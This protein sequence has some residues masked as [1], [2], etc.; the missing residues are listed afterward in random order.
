LYHQEAW[1]EQEKSI[2]EDQS[3]EAHRQGYE[4]E[5]EDLEVIPAPGSRGYG[6]ARQCPRGRSSCKCREDADI[7]PTNS[8]NSTAP[9][10]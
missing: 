2:G 5:K 8:T 6:M 1:E 9:W 3:M 7:T 10:G 4:R